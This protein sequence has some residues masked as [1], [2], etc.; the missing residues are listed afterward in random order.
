MNI[1]TLFA[2]LPA[3]AIAPAVQ[4]QDQSDSAAIRA[5]WNIAVTS[6]I[7]CHV[8]SPDQAL[9]PVLGP[10]IPAFA[11]IANR[12]DVTA[13]SLQASMKIARW[14]NDALPFTLLPMSRLSDRERAEVVAYI[15]TL[16]NRR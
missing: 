5:G 8:V 12:P 9:A 7:S 3:L 14:H 2:L 15:M 1:R 6:C 13:E 16:R 11:E 10:G 4:G